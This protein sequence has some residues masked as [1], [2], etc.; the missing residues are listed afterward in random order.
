MYSIER[1]SDEFRRLGLAPGDAVMA[2]SALRSLGP[3]ENGAEGVIQALWR[4]LGEGGTLLMP[5]LSYKTVHAAHPYFHVNDTPSCVGALPEFF[6]RRAGVSRS[7]H[8][9][10][11]ACAMGARAACFVA[12]HENDRTP[13]GAYSPF[14]KLREAGG[15][16]LFIGCGLRPNTSMHA[17]EE[18][19]EPPYLY[20][21]KV[22][23][24][25]IRLPGGAET[26]MRVR[27]HGFA[28]WEQRYDRVA[29][30]LQPPYIARGKV[31]DAD[32]WLLDAPAL[33]REVGRA[34][35]KN[36]LFFV[37]PL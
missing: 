13:C 9:T 35:T 4:A 11:S 5:A 19:H 34:L 33:W 7:V 16:I 14:R 25:R 6:R 3:I 26:R 30:V 12:G 28:G 22:V 18:L 37:D 1:I 31:G 23:E 36:P 24:Y 21:P 10:H 8:P 2:H 17:V 32:C 29:E 15:K 27:E 20:G